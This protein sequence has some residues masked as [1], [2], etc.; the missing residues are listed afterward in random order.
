[1]RIVITGSSSGIGQHLAEKLTAA[2][3]EIWGLARSA[4]KAVYATSVCDVSQWA[5]VERARAEI[6]QRWPHVDAVI[7]AAAIQGAIGPAMQ[8]EP[9][10]WS[11][12]IRVDLDG[13]Y[14][15]VRAFWDLLRQS[16][17]RAKVI[18]FSGGGAT[19][20]RPNFSAYAAAKTGVVR[21]VETLAAEWQGVSIDINA[22]A[23]GAINTAMTRE[24]ARLGPEF[25]GCEEYEAAQRQLTQGGQSIEKAFGLVEFLL[26]E[27]SDGLTGRLL[28]AQWDNW[29]G[30][31]AHA[32]K[33][34]E[35]EIY[36]LRRILPEERGV[37]F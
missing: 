3:H 32:A 28:S 7:C 29:A 35:S 14:F 25:S 22:V 23:P 6:A 1:M 5:Q 2:G 30:L 8:V 4:Q 15:V 11:E 26:S 20:A 12:T 24:T 34:A 31:P 19:K 9:Q 33:L 17:R 37:K 10:R 21:L 13:T 27:E 36:Q 16:P 18:C